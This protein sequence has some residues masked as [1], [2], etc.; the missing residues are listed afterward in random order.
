MCQPRLASSANIQQQPLNTNPTCIRNSYFFSYL[1]F[2]RK[3]IRHQL[4]ESLH[5]QKHTPLCTHGTPKA[6]PTCPPIDGHA[7]LDQIK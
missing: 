1:T 3:S 2:C 6:D 4:L 5:P 7:Q